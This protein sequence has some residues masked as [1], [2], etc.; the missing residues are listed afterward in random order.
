M[1]TKAVIFDI[2]GTLVTTNKS[3]RV[4]VVR[5]TLHELGIGHRIADLDGFWFGRYCS[6]DIEDML[7]IDA[8][9]FWETFTKHDSIKKRMEMTVTFSD[10]GAL[11]FLVN[12]G[13]KMGAVSDALSHVAYGNLEQIGLGYFSSVVITNKKEGLPAKPDPLGLLLCLEELGVKPNEAIYVGNSSGDILT[14]RNAGVHDVIVQR[15]EYPLSLT[16]SFSINSLYELTS[17]VHGASTDY[18][19]Q[20]LGGIA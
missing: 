14:G 13:I 20:S 2:D 12:D 3:Y 8:D 4:A 16:P 19:F 1:K 9:K 5:N 6:H 7:Q 11:D 10:I 17:V 15:R 18:K